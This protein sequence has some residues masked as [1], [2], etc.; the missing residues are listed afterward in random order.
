LATF[1]AQK[2][3]EH[4][5]GGGGTTM[6]VLADN[7][8]LDATTRDL[9]TSLG[10]RGIVD[11][12]WRYDQRDN[13]YK[14]LDVNLRMGANFRLFV[15]AN[16]MDV[17]RAQYLDLTGQEVPAPTPNGGRRW[18][19]EPFDLWA[20]AGYQRAGELTFRAWLS[21][22]RGVQE[23]A[24]FARDDVKPFLAMALLFVLQPPYRGLK[25]LRRLL[26]RRRSDEPRPAPP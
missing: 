9:L 6:G 1:L 21:S 16:G 22:F 4:P 10:Y 23:G 19:V 13:S 17:V 18:V 24:W 3:R 2:I 5:P 12:D 14:L 11:L 25:R 7:P 15:G 20:S 26:S 8:D